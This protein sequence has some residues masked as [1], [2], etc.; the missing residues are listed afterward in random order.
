MKRISERG[1]LERLDGNAAG[2]GRL[3]PG[4]DHGHASGDIRKK[5]RNRAK[6]VRHVVV[7]GRSGLYL[8]EIE[9]PRVFRN[10]IDLDAMA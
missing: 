6:I 7:E 1:G 4:I 8:P 2:G 9:P 10:Q 5:P 3:S